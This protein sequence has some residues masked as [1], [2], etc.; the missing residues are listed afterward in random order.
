MPCDVCDQYS[1]HKI[2]LRNWTFP[3]YPSFTK[4]DGTFDPLH[5]KLV[6][7]NVRLWIHPENQTTSKSPVRDSN[8]SETSINEY[9][10]E[11]SIVYSKRNTISEI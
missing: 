2:E 5:G 3:T 1:L 9:L 7:Q 11:V 4:N 6:L 10:S 8:E